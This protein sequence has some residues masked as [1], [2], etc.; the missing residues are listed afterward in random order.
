MRSRST[1][2]TFRLSLWVRSAEDRDAPGTTDVPEGRR[3]E[4]CVVRDPIDLSLGPDGGANLVT[5]QS[6]RHVHGPDHEGDHRG[7]AWIDEAEALEAERVGGA[8]RCSPP[9]RRRG[10]TALDSAPARGQCGRVIT[11]RVFLCSFTHRWLA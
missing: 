8:R 3:L 9:P 4:A 1:E 5:A 2:A 7:V 10:P 11:R 6:R